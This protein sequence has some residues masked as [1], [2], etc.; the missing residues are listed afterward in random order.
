MVLLEC[1]YKERS[2]WYM[3]TRI[4]MIV[5]S[6][7]KHSTTIT[8]ITAAAASYKDKDKDVLVLLNLKLKFLLPFS[9]LSSYIYMIVTIEFSIIADQ[10]KLVAALAFIFI[11]LV[12]S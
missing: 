12:L 8:T 1:V 3:N 6:K 11:R 10:Q 5:L 2:I 7:L 4:A 9:I